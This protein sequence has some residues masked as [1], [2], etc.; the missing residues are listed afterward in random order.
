WCLAELGVRNINVRNLQRIESGAVPAIV[1]GVLPV[2]DQRHPWG[3]EWMSCD[4]QLCIGRVDP[5][6]Q[7][8]SGAFELPAVCIANHKA[9][10]LELYAI[11]I[12]CIFGSF[13][14][15]IAQAETEGG[16]RVVGVVL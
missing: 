10:G 9:A 12:E 6:A 13:H 2:M 7:F 1:L 4:L 14:R 16:Q 5:D 3:G 15:N 11:G 8:F